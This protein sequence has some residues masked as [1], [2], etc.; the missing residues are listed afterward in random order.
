MGCLSLVSLGTDVVHLRRRCRLL[1][2][3][4]LGTAS[5]A[6]AWPGLWR[7]GGRQLGCS[8]GEA[9]GVCRVACWSQ[10][11]T[12]GQHSVPV[13]RGR[14]HGGGGGAKSG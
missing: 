12:S 10:R 5:A 2:P 7:A 13:R 4:E 8:R 6:A 11:G 9:F 14:G 1:G 3:V